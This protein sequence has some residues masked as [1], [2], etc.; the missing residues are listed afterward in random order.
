MNRY[1]GAGRYAPTDTARRVAGRHLTMLGLV[2]L[3]A[4]LGACTT[5]APTPTPDLA[6]TFPVA[7]LEP[8]GSETPAGCPAAVIEGTL[9]A[10]EATGL[11]LQG[12][13][14]GAVQVLWPFGY[15]GQTGPPVALIDDQGQVVAVVGQ[16]ISIG[17]GAVG[18]HG[19]WLACGGIAVRD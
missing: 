18:P 2:V 11:G 4:V 12:P 17:G 9:V 13:D 8:E 1:A 6:G 7:T 14:V 3:V 16:R 5:F 19:E 15:R 10:N